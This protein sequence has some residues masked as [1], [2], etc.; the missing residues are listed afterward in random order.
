MMTFFFSCLQECTEMLIDIFSLAAFLES[1]F[2][3]WS[4]QINLFFVAFS[5]Y[6]CTLIFPRFRAIT[7]HRCGVNF[8]G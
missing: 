3:R 6:F 7:E 2:Q 5:R 4:W 1:L 8:Q